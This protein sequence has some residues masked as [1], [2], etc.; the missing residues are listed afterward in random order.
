MEVETMEKQVF[1]STKG[2]KA[3]GPY[4][5]ATIL[6][7]LVFVSGQGPI[8]PET[9]KLHADD[10]VE[11]QTRRVLENVKIILEELGSSLDKVLKCGVYLSD[12]N[13]FQKMN[14]VYAEFFSQNPPAR[15]TIQAGRLPFDIKVEIECIASL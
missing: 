5:S 8:D 3:R 6:D 9:D 4:S 13:D 11:E 10:T 1:N 14:G 7:N 12:M 15:T 2:P